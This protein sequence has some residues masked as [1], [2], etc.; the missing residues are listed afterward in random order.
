M[1]IFLFAWVPYAAVSFFNAFI[2]D[3]VG[4]PL[5]STI[6]AFFAKSSVVWSSLFY[7]CTDVKMKSLVK[8]RILKMLTNQH[9]NSDN[10][11]KQRILFFYVILRHRLNVVAVD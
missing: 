5:L 4:Y 6:P 9:I 7:L 1:S 3:S 10:G 11:N 8:I 2:S